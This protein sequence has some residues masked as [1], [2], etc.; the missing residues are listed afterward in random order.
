MNARPSRACVCITAWCS[1]QQA[2]EAASSSSSSSAPATSASSSAGSSSSGVRAGSSSTP[3]SNG[4]ATPIINWLIV[5]DAPSNGGSGCRRWRRLARGL[6]QACCCDDPASPEPTSVFCRLDATEGALAG[7]A[8]CLA[9]AMPGVCEAIPLPAAISASAAAFA[10]T[11]RGESGTR[12]VSPS[13]PPVL[14]ALRIDSSSP[15]VAPKSS[16]SKSAASLP[17]VAAA[18]L[19]CSAGYRYSPPATWTGRGGIVFRAAA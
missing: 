1:L 16:A 13:S 5:G 9:A 3:P 12:G 8:S 17:V 4:G 19:G 2:S 14:P 7:R 11:R 6:M 10:V 18:W 15:N